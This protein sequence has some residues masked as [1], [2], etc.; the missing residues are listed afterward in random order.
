MGSE[1]GSANPRMGS[2]EK[3]DYSSSQG[4]YQQ[5]LNHQAL[6]GGGSLGGDDLLEEEEYLDELD[7]RNDIYTAKGATG[8]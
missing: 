4:A 5:H 6:Y 3:D 7:E 8:H 2:A 1:G